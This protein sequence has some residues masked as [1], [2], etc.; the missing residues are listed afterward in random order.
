MADDTQPVYLPAAPSSALI[1][2]IVFIDAR[3]PDL[4]DLIAAVKPGDQ[5]FVLD[6]A[7][8]GLDQIAKILAASDLAGIA[9]ISIV[10]HGAADQIELG[11][12]LITDGNL[13][14]HSAD[15]ATIGA[16]LAP[17][18]DLLLYSC[19]V[20]SGAAGQQFI[21]DLASFT[22]ADV[23]AATHPVGSADLGGSWVL[24]A[25]TGPI[26]ASSPFITASLGNFSGLLPTPTLTAVQSTVLT[27][28][29]DGDGVADP[30]DTLTTS[31]VITNTSATDAT[32]VS[33]TETLDHLTLVAGKI[34]VSPLAFDD[35]Y[36]TVGN[37]QL[38]VNA[39]GTNPGS[40]PAVIV[41]GN[42]FTNDTEFL[43]DTFSL[44]S[45][46]QGGH[47]SVTVNSDGTFTYLPNAGFTGS[48]TFAYTLTDKGLDGI[49]GNADDLTGVGTVHITV[50]TVVWYVNSAAGA[51][52]TGQSTSPFNAITATNLNGA[53]GAGDLDSAGNYIYLE[54][55]GTYSATL[56]LETGEHLIGGGEALVVDGITLGSAGSRPTLSASSGTALTLADGNDVEGLNVT[57]SAGSGITGSAVGTLTLK[58]F[59]STATGT[60]LG[61]STS[62]TVTA[63]GTNVLSSSAGT[64]L[65]VTNVTI[66]AGNITFQSISAGSASGSAP[67]GIILDTTGSSGGLHVTGV[68]T[69]A[70]SG[71]TIQH[72]TGADGSTTTGIGIYLNSTSGVQLADMQLNDFQNFGNL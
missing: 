64:A 23:A 26:E 2:D 15:L 42:L 53:G 39:S 51:G 71:G 54:G 12:T 36:T 30:G 33:F 68:G 61:L 3:V 38:I 46:T 58:D 8:D 50:G 43:G 60:A 35:F 19:D 65:S 1:R 7:S 34:N 21:A 14:E 48:D 28:D 10:G 56:G 31:V 24:D 22:G 29:V 4:P 11:S 40:T 9:S 47:G 52:G 32:G 41:V 44:K 49:A 72:K 20:A 13:A 62:G 37:T 17:G 66:G 69:T 55:S 63:T 18:G 25:S 70:G 57:N 5:V 6:P 45:F 27:T 59:N 67:D 16:S